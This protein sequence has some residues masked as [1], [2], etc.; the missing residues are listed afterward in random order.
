MND[1]LTH[2]NIRKLQSSSNP[3]IY[4]QHLVFFHVERGKIDTMLSWWN[5]DGNKVI[6]TIIFTSSTYTSAWD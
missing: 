4:L 3:S 6:A 5:E 1:M 2:F